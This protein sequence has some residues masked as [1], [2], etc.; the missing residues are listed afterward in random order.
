MGK[1][2]LPDEIDELFG[3]APVG[4]CYLDVETRF[5][6]IN[7]WLAAINGL[8]VDEHLG[9]PIDQVLPA[10]AAGV[11]G[12]LRHVLRTGEPII[13]GEIAAT[14]PAH[15]EEV[16][17]YQH[18]YFPRRDEDGTVVG[19]SCFVQDI[20][21]RRQAEAELRKA[22]DELEQRVEERTR[23]LKER[24]EQLRRSQKMEAVGRLAGGIA[25]D[26]NNVLTVIRGSVDLISS[27]GEAHPSLKEDL[28]R[29]EKAAE[30]ASGLTRQ[31]LAFARKQVLEPRVVD[32]NELILDVSDMLARL[33]SEDIEM[34]VTADPEPQPVE[35]DVGQ[36]EQVIVNLATNARDA[37]PSGGKLTIKVEGTELT[38]EDVKKL[39][40]L[41]AGR[42]AVLSVTD[43]GIGM[44]E[45]TRERLFEPFFSTKEEGKGAGLGLA[46]SYGIVEQSGG[47][48]VVDSSPG[49]GS[50]FRV[51]LPRAVA[52]PTPDADPPEAAPLP[53]SEKILLVEDE[54][55]VRRVIRKVL[56]Q[57]GHEVLDT[58]DPE[59]A[60][61]MAD[62][63]IDLLVTDEVM[64][65]LHGRELA[66]RLRQAFPNLKVLVMSGYAEDIAT[67]E[68]KGEN[69]LSKPFSNATL[70]RKVREVLDR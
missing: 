45:D 3:E 20:T 53:G 65:K 26:F 34:S 68:S 59:L 66:A 47:H 37:M 38:E 44:D 11:E 32:L 49:K 60:L 25:H 69:F 35:V 29:I 8:T 22:N 16:R 33:I 19:V 31:L 67:G 39:G 18:N 12:Q 27:A 54:A 9:K 10:V 1:K 61:T 70:V 62:P 14:T 36:L 24:H 40:I 23:E 63:S 56:Q 17:T 43:T 48:I 41:N 2:H 21:L 15:P 55:E 64:P 13:D 5:V 28:D 7:N 52:M 42:Y 30:R 50:C 57:S 6:Y 46:T 51:Y 58:G 4:L